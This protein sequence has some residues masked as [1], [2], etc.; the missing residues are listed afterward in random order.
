MYKFHKSQKQGKTFKEPDTEKSLNPWDIKLKPG[1]TVLK[2]TANL[3]SIDE[4]IKR[5][6]K[7]FRENYKNEL[8]QKDLKIDNKES[9]TL[10]DNCSEKRETFCNN[11]LPDSMNDLSFNIK[12]HEKNNALPSISPQTNKENSPLSSN[13][14]QSDKKMLPNMNFKRTYSDIDSTVKRVFPKRSFVTKAAIINMESL[15]Y[16]EKSF[17]QS[18]VP[19]NQSESSISGLVTNEPKTSISKFQPISRDIIIEPPTKKMRST[20][21]DTGKVQGIQK[22]NQNFLKLNMKFKGYCTKAT[23]KQRS[24]RNGIRRTKWNN[25]MRGFGR[26][27]R[28]GEEG[29]YSDKCPIRPVYGPRDEKSDQNAMGFTD[30]NDAI[31][32]ADFSCNRIMLHVIRANIP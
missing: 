8:K 26:C 32:V 9:V 13:V 27:F 29:H 30:L 1:T 3:R 24:T 25:K 17:Q 7:T 21:Q 23:A 20:V 15:T 28:C 31:K 11:L 5:N 6:T 14:S 22:G 16:D 19:E 12:T 10:P 4:I 2:E 18:F